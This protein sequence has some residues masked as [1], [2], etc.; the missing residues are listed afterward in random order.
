MPHGRWC[1]CRAAPPDSPPRGPAEE[2]DACFIVR[3]GNGQA[4]AAGAGKAGG[5]ASPHPRL[6]RRIAA[7]ITQ[8]FLA[9]N[10]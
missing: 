2:T 3:D 8:T 5:D 6:A 7:N 9:P 10:L 4:L 1:R